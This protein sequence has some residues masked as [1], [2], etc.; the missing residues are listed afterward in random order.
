MATPVRLFVAVS[1][2]WAVIALAVQV[3]TAW[4]G[5]RKDYSRPAGS[6]LRGL[7]Y[8]FT[9]AMTPTHKETIRLHPFKFA[10]GL[11]M[12]VGVVLAMLAAAALLV[13]PSGG[14]RLA[15]L[16][17]PLFGVSLLAGLYL[18]VRRILSRNLR[19]M[20]VPDDYFAVLAT[21]G[22]LAFACA[23]ALGGEREVPFLVYA[24]LLLHRP[25]GPGSPA[26]LSG[27]VSTSDGR[28]GV[29]DG[30]AGQPPGRHRRR[31]V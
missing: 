26:R 4:G 30:G 19:F 17:G 24:G 20:S 10:L 8:G 12:H 7:V 2:A 15:E 13:W 3:V 11:I 21:C 23:Y 27:G 22:L 6:P 18:L 9:G 25:R 5:G 29:G 28:Y 31:G 1:I 16:G 14:R